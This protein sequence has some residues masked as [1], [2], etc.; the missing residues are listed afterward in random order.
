MKELYCFVLTQNVLLNSGKVLELVKHKVPKQAQ[1]LFD[2]SPLF[3]NSTACLAVI[4]DN[5]CME[6]K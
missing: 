3:A 4:S 1:A 6:S 5:M 2:L